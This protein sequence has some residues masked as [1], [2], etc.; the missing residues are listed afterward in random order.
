MRQHHR[1][2]SAGRQE[3]RRIRMA[4][5]LEAGRSKS[6]WGQAKRICFHFGGDVSCGALL[7]ARVAKWQTHGT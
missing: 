3:S 6:G 7:D 2:S 4:R 5:A 1:V